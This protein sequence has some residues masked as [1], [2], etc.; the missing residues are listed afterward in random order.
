MF[1][2]FAEASPVRKPVWSDATTCEPSVVWGV[3]H[4]VSSISFVH[5]WVF[6]LQLNLSFSALWNRLE[7]VHVMFS[8]FLLASSRLLLAEL[9]AS[10][11]PSTWEVDALWALDS[12]EI[13]SFSIRNQSPE[14]THKPISEA[15]HSAAPSLPPIMPCLAVLWQVECQSPQL[16]FLTNIHIQI[17]MWSFCT[18][19]YKKGSKV[20]SEDQ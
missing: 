8:E 19:P 6:F 13:L 11:L 9:W 20:T 4:I 14:N 15:S 7:F 3:K 16:D 1:I 2:V 12:G 10:F 5:L 18:H 17:C